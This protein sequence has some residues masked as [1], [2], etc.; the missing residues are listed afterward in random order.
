MRISDWSSDVCSSDLGDRTDREYVDADASGSGE[1][2]RAAVDVDG[3]VGDHVD[4]RLV[5]A[6]QIDG[7]AVDGHVARAAGDLNASD[8]HALNAG[9]GD[10]D[11]TGRRREDRMARGDQGVDRKSTRLNSSH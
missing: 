3:T 7:A 11:R 4:A 10:V 5:V 9:A 2:D 1:V 6:G 8:I